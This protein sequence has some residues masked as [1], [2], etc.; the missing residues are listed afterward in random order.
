[1]SLS[2]DNGEHLLEAFTQRGTTEKLCRDSLLEHGKVA[3][4]ITPRK[5]VY[6]VSHK[7]RSWGRSRLLPM[8]N[9]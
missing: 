2:A 7:E 4:Y 5:R 9:N 1:M 6:D 3:L 8:E